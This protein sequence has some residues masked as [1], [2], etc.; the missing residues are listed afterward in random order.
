MKLSDHIYIPILK[1]ALPLILIQLCQASLGLINT[2]VAGQYSYQ[3]LAAVGLGSSIWT[4]VFILF[5]G[6]LYVLVPK[7]SMLEK[8]KDDSKMNAL[9][10]QGKYI[11]LILSIFGFIF[12]HILAFLCPL[13][14]EDQQ[15]AP[16]TQHY[17]HFIAFAVPGLVYMTLY[18]FISEGSSLL[19]PIMLTFIVLLLCDAILSYILVNGMGVVSALGGAGTGLANVFSAYIACFVMRYYV[20]QA[21]PAI[22]AQHIQVS[23][24]DSLNVLKQGLPIGVTLVLQI[25]ALSML[26]F[27]ASELGTRTIAA[28]Q[29]VINIAMVIIMIPV[30]M[31]SAVTIRIATF[32]AENN[33]QGK[34]LTAITSAILT[35]C[36][37]LIMAMI[38]VLFGGQLTALFSQDHQVIELATGLIK[39]VAIFLIFDALQMVAAGVLRGLEQ[40]VHPL[41]VI[42]CCYWII[43]IPLSYLMGVK[44]WL[45]VTANV[46]IIWKILA[47]GMCIAAIAMIIQS[48]R[49][50]QQTHIVNRI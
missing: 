33:Q 36:Y 42:L 2:L 30:A 43:V 29:I 1:L 9:F 47:T 7:I 44:G 35:L 48:Y 13:L 18:R 38:L 26:A 6:I 16:I 19:K 25:L 3:D 8:N 46:D 12:V 28:H 23:F 49:K 15:V 45:Q 50:I 17:L 4:P 11:A 37:G 21:V 34:Q 14:I 27:F 24:V 5:T 31:S 39:Y 41:I 32:S 10:K 22:K 40:F 20:R